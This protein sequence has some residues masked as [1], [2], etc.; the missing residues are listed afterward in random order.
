MYALTRIMGGKVPAVRFY[1]AGPLSIPHN[2]LDVAEGH[3]GA[4]G[5]DAEGGAVLD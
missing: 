4:G 3:D 5:N 2:S 1:P